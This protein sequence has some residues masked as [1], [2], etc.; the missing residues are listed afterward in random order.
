MK[1]GQEAHF[2]AGQIFTLVIAAVA[3]LPR[4]PSDASGCTIGGKLSHPFRRSLI[5]LVGIN[6]IRVVGCHLHHPDSL[7]LKTLDLILGTTHVVGQSFLCLTTAYILQCQLSNYININPGRDLLPVLCVVFGL[8]VLGAVLSE[9]RNPNFWCL[10][11]L[12]EGISC[13]PVLRT[14]KTYASVTTV[15]GQHQGRGS[16]LI[17]TLRTMEVCYL[18]TCVLSFFAEM[19][20]DIHGN[21]DLAEGRPLKIVFEAIRQNQDNGIDDWT[22]LLVHS[23]FLNSIDEMEHFTGNTGSSKSSEAGHASTVNTSTNGSNDIETVD[24]VQPLVTVQRRR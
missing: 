11:N 13:W 12:A 4:M 21:P 20:D 10:V 2:L 1:A 14:L 5:F 8:T 22:R 16:I 24:L 18:T 3:V 15:G 19:L 9:V 17:Q 7:Q 6:V 23:I